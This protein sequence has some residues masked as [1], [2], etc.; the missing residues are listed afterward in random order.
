MIGRRELLAAAT[1]LPWSAAPARAASAMALPPLA[2]SDRSL[3]NGLRVVGLPMPGLGSVALQVWYRV[4]GKDD[5]PGRSGFAHLFEHLMFK[6]T[7]HLPDEAFDRLTEDVG[8]SNNAFTAADT[9]VYT[10]E[11]PANHLERLLWAEAERMHNLRV[12]QA[13]FAS[14]RE[15]VK[16]ELRER[17]QADPYGRLFESLPGL[18]YLRHPY[19]RP[20]IGSIAELDAATLADVQRFHATY[21]RP[22]NAVLVVAGGFDPADFERLVDRHFGPL[23]APRTPIPRVDVTEPRRHAARRVDL[24]APIVP[25][26]ALAIVWQGPRAGAADAPALQVASAL[27]SQG[28]SSRFNET[29]VYRDRLA[30]SAGFWADLNADAG[31]LVAYAVAAG[32]RTLA[33]LEKALLAQI[34]RL[35]A[36]PVADS[37]LDKVRTQLQTAVIAA[38]QTPPGQAEAAGWALINHGDPREAQG[39]IARLQAVGVADVQR[40]LRRHLLERRAVTVHYSQ[41]GGRR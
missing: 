40:V 20:V 13:N 32:G 18:A 11:V 26:P 7:A 41:Q 34:R 22:D 14:E 25:L 10:N 39:E 29:L 4:G 30:Q 15:V 12:D 36:E 2:L 33:A 9:T 6:R 21:Y 27:L 3:A 17:V 19:K 24:H 5:P 28:D 37:E 35:A 38:R 8:G 16:E 31:M 1:A 23:S